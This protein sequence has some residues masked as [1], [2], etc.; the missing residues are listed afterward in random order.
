MI[1]RRM[2][3]LLAGLLVLAL[4]APSCVWVH[5]TSS[6]YKGSK[7]RESLP[8]PPPAGVAA[9]VTQPPVQQED[10]YLFSVYYP[11]ASTVNLAGTFNSW[12]PESIPMT[13]AEGDGIWTV[14][15]YVLPGNHEYKYS[16]NGGAKWVADAAN[17]NYVTDPYGGRNSVLIVPSPVEPLEPV[18]P[19]ESEETE[20]AG[21]VE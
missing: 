4:V 17:N 13:E 1:T 15:V 11:G 16:I 19:V 10:G 7:G 18:E 2:V 6:S 20:E 5:D 8:P 21:E 9:Q 14:V 3:A 12:N